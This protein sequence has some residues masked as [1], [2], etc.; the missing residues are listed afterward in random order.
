MKKIIL[1]PL[2]FLAS[3]VYSQ[4]KKGLARVSKVLGVEVYVMCEPEREYEIV[5]TLNTA[6]TTMLSNRESI[7]NQMK[8]VVGRAQNKKK[9]GK[10]GDFDA[11]ITQDG[12]VMII[13]KFKD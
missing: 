12:D 7:A 10:I 8:E 9:K 5:E 1:I 11:V 3:M 2:L 6:F 4:D 13:V